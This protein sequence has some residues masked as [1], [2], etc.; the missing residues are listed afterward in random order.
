M[1]PVL[2]LVTGL[3][4]Y[5]YT[6]MFYRAAI[7]TYIAWSALCCLFAAA[8]AELWRSVRPPAT[9]RKRANATERED[10]LTLVT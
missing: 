3:V 4:L 6:M 1:E 2:S 9:E 5:S 7:G 10:D 8:V